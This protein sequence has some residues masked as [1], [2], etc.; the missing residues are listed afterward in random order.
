MVEI[1]ISMARG[2]VVQ[3]AVAL[4]TPAAEFIKDCPAVYFAEFARQ[5]SVEATAL[6]RFAVLVGDTRLIL[7]AVVNSLAE[8]TLALTAGTP[9]IVD[10]EQ[11]EGFRA[12]HNRQYFSRWAS[13]M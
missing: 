2:T 5:S 3:F 13:R 12:Q 9:R 1:E 7:D 8:A 6:C 4:E 10:I 11:F